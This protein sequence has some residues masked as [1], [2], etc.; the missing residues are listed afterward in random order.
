MRIFHVCTTGKFSKR[1]FGRHIYRLLVVKWMR[2]TI[3]SEKYLI[4]NKTVSIRLF[5][6]NNNNKKEYPALL[7]AKNTIYIFKFLK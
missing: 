2:K 3:S 6:K 5:N 1:F 4:S 7:N